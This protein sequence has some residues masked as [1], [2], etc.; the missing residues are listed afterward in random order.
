MVTSAKTKKIKVF[1]FKLPDIIVSIASP[2]IYAGTKASTIINNKNIN[3]SK[4]VFHSFF[5]NQ[6]NFL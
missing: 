1:V 2:K 5:I 4:Y 3:N 6:L